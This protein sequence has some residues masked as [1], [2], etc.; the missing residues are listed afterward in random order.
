MTYPFNFLETLGIVF[1]AAIVFSA[2]VFWLEIRH[3]GHNEN[4][5]NDENY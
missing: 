4:L 3:A 5:D 2:L 1:I